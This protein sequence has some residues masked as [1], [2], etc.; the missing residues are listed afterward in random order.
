MKVNI[1]GEKYVHV[2]K[3][4]GQISEDIITKKEYLS[5][6]EPG[7]KSPA[8]KGWEWSLSKCCPLFDTPSGN[9]EDGQYADIDGKTLS[10]KEGKITCK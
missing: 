7:A 3:K 10:N 4:D 9:L 5:L 1:I 2:F 6:S 8:K